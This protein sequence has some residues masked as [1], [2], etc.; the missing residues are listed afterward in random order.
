MTGQST[1]TDA[2]VLVVGGGAI[3]GVVAARL[4]EG[5]IRVTVLDADPGH[6]ARMRDPG[7]HVDLLGRERTV[8]LEAHSEPA[9][10]EGRFDV[11]L[12]TVK[13][14]AIEAALAPLEAREI[15]DLYVSLGNGLVQERCAAV[16]GWHRLMVGI[17]EWGASNLR[18]GHVAQTTEAPIIIG[19]PDGT[20]Q[21]R[22]TELGQTL[23][24]VAEVRVTKNIWGHVWT[25]LLLNATFSGLGT[26]MGGSYRDLVWHPDGLAAIT[27]VWTEAHRVAGHLGITLE[28]LL[29]FDADSLCSDADPEASTP[30]LE[31][32]TRRLGRTK[33]SM[34]Q[35]L[36]RGIATE[37]G[38]INGAVADRAEAAKT[39][40]PINQQV[41]RLIRSMEQRTLIPAPELLRQVAAAR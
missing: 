13:S 40:A 1:A 22:T 12:V 23:E 29:G 2:R 21:S 32:I 35:D 27:A 39:S 14:R 41:V 7:L 8:P 20:L 30:A 37:V 15:V 38:V 36:E 28:P 18:P 10:L 31:T 26:V 6:V 16:V 34:L 19:E 9:E 11:A 3:G 4:A 25:K 17:V 5:R 33:P 24:T